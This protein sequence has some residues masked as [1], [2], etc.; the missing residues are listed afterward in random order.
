MS[1]LIDHL[2]HN[3]MKRYETSP[4]T[5]LFWRSAGKAEAGCWIWT[6][7]SNVQGY[8]VFKS[9]RRQYRAHRF[10]YELHHGAIPIGMMVCHKCDTPACVNPDHLFLGTAQDN[11]SDMVTKGRSLCGKLNHCTKLTDDAVRAIRARYAAGG[12][13]LVALGR[14][15]GVASATIGKVVKRIQW[16]HVP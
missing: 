14:E 7:A 12:V 11:M 9:K 8:G 1:G 15:Y 4:K 6:G 3:R 13:T 10:S 5:A 16:R 2:I